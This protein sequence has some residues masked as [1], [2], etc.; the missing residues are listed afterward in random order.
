MRGSPNALGGCDHVLLSLG[1]AHHATNNGDETAGS[2]EAPRDIHHDPPQYSLPTISSNSSPSPSAAVDSVEP[3][4][5]ASAPP[6]AGPH[7]GDTTSRTRH[8]P[9]P[10]LPPF[11]WAMHPSISPKGPVGSI[12]SSQPRRSRHDSTKAPRKEPVRQANKA[13]FRAWS[14]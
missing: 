9:L 6:R 11:A 12:S 3:R 4:P 7:E 8:S 2:P 5:R 13:T 1:F 14:R 10:V